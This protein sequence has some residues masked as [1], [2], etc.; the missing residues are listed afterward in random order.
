MTGPRGR[1]AG[2]AAVAAVFACACFALLAGQ[3]ARTSRSAIVGVNADMAQARLAAAA[4]A[5]VAMAVDHLLADDPSARW[6]ADGAVQQAPLGDIQLRIRVEDERGK[7]PLNRLSEDQA[8]TLFQAAGVD[9]ASLSAITAIF[10]AQ[11]DPD[12]R[13]TPLAG[14]NAEADE[15]GGFRTIQQLRRLPGVTAPVYAALAPFVTVDAGDVRFEPSLASPLALQVMSPASQDGVGSIE[16][17]REAEGERTALD[18]APPPSLDYA[19]RVM[20]VRVEASD[21]QGGRFDDA[22][23]IQITG[24][25]AQPFIVRQHYGP[26]GSAG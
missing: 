26:L 5:G 12:Q 4:Q 6:P 19:G 23:I 16:R 20:T 11:L 2:Y 15:G 21:G 17:Q 14:A 7:I 8:R 18:T 10:M 25:P 9:P 1:E 3:V 22:E 24:R 13:G